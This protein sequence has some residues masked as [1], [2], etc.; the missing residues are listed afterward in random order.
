MAGGAYIPVLLVLFALLT[1]VLYL[2]WHLKARRAAAAEALTPDDD[3]VPESV[4]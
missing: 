2:P 1:T 3:A 4:R